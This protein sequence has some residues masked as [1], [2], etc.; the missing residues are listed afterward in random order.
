MPVVVTVVVVMGGM[1]MVLAVVGRGGGD[2]SF[3][4]ESGVRLWVW[5]W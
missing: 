3:G 1:G 4:C 5:G 2:V